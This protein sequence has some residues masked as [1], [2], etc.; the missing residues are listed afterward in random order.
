[1]SAFNVVVYTTILLFFCMEYFLHYKYVNVIKPG[2]TEKQRAH[3]LSI[4]NSLS[5]LLIGIYF[6]YYYFT[7][8]FNEDAF[9][10]ILE[11]KGS[12]SFGKVIVLYFTAYL[13]MDVYIGS[14][15]Y[16]SF[17]NSLSGNLHHV[18]YSCV[19]VISLYIGVYPLYLVMMLSELPTL[20]LSIG[21]FDE[22][23]RDD[24]LFGITFFLT[25]IVYHIILTWMFRGHKVFLGISLAAL[26][27]H[28]YWFYGWVTKYYAP[29]TPHTPV[30]VK[31]P[32]KSQT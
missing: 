24:N 5:M 19:N 3:I 6:N 21:R 18:I 8:K 22:K 16:P 20:I 12:L 29:L 2:M 23:L 31:T 17:M 11:E 27:L 7:S 15:E 9:Y 30:K 14:T 4:K 1:M 32:L 28:I 10:N 26:S 13:I 25:R